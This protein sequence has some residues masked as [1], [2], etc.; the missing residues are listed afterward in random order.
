MFLLISCSM[1]ALFWS[2]L[3][4]LHEII[5]VKYR[6]SCVASFSRFSFFQTWF[7]QFF[8]RVFM[9]FLL[10]PSKF[11]SRNFIFFPFNSR[12]GS[13]TFRLILVVS[14]LYSLDFP[15]KF[16]SSNLLLSPVASSNIYFFIPF[17]SSYFLSVKKS[18]L[19]PCPKIYWRSY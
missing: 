16:N 9:C 15:S 19:L 12:T 10:V 2:F 7:A 3:W 11:I 1:I 13:S 8:F 17:P 5:E 18:F 6:C 14:I 4:T